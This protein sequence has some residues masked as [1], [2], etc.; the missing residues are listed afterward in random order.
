MAVDVI[1]SGVRRSQL[2]SPGA[3]SP[4]LQVGPAQGGFED[5]PPAAP[6]SRCGLRSAGARIGF[7]HIVQVVPYSC[8]L[9]RRGGVDGAGGYGPVCPR[10]GSRRLGASPRP[11]QDRRRQSPDRS[12]SRATV[13]SPGRVF[14]SEDALG[15]PPFP[16]SAR[17]AGRAA[18]ARARRRS[19]TDTRNAT[20]VAFRH[21]LRLRVDDLPVRLPAA[22]D[23]KPPAG[24]AH[25][26][27]PPSRFICS[28]SRACPNDVPTTQSGP[29][30]P[31]DVA[32]PSAAVRRSRGQP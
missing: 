12:G 9:A 21:S 2:E 30:D 15:F 19:T 13:D 16:R 29:E 23:V 6:S 22:S 3:G 5:A 32:R 24:A 7:T 14:G 31:G 25:F 17:R 4:C 20:L 18:R 27:E 11:T 10:G 28:R 8:S 26:G 1:R